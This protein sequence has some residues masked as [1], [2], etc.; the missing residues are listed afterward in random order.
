[1]RPEAVQAVGLLDEAFFMYGE[2]VDWCRRCWKAGWQVVFFPG[3][4]AVHH[5]GAS[6]AIEP[7]RTAVEQQR[8]LLHYWSKHHGWFGLLGIQSI[9]FCHNMLRYLFGVATRF[10]RSSKDARKDVRTKVSIACLK[11][12]I[13]PSARCEV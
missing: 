12:L 3:A 2:D 1:M 7:V 5:R 6:S 9:L 11:A 4:K 8:S 13:S 10:F